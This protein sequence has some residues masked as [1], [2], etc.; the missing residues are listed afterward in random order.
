MEKEKLILETTK[1]AVE[2]KEQGRKEAI[3]EVLEYLKE[4]LDYFK[5]IDVA[6]ELIER[7]IK[8]VEKLKDGK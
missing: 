8:R 5:E 4:E 7:I 2:C 1:F 3:D 6:V